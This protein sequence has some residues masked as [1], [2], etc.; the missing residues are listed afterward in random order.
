[1]RTF[2][3]T[4]DAAYPADPRSLY[5]AILDPRREWPGN[6]ILW[7]RVEDGTTVI[8]RGRPRGVGQG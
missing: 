7:V 6:G 5:D 4:I 1:M 3:S 2:A 8:L